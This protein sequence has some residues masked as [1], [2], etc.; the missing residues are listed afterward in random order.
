MVP[1]PNEQP[2]QIKTV[3][4]MKV[5][6][7]NVNRVGVGM[8]LQRSEHSTAE[9][10]RKRRGVWCGQEVS[11]RWRIGPD[12]AAGATENGDSHAH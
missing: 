2:G 11:G 9:V 10:D 8:A 1:A 3:V 12:N 6:E 7:K 4:G 5:G